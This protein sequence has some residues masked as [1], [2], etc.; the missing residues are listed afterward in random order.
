MFSVPCSV[1]GAE[2]FCPT[3]S[4]LYWRIQFWGSGHLTRLHTVLYSGFCLYLIKHDKNICPESHTHRNTSE[5]WRWKRQRWRKSSGDLK[6]TQKL[7]P[8]KGH[9]LSAHLHEGDVAISH[10]W[11]AWI[12]MNFIIAAQPRGLSL[13][14]THTHPLCILSND[15]CPRSLALAAC[16][17]TRGGVW[18]P[19]GAILER[20]IRI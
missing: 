5:M 14:L 15:L 2:I 6:T 7:I 8:I 13:S 1:S 9:I 16:K 12:Q 4:A 10:K 20:L 11:N 3:G 18:R 19:P 17:L